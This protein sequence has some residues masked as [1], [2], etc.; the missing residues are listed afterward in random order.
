MEPD[1]RG[2][3]R[4]L[5]EEFHRRH[6][7]I[8]IRL[9]EGPASTDAREDLYVNALL[10]GTGD[11]DLVYADTIWIPKFASAGWL[12][13]LT[14]RWPRERWDDFVPA[15][16]QGGTH[17]SRIYR[18]PVQLNGGLLYYRRDLIGDDPPA[19]FEE[20]VQMAKQHATADGRWGF[21]WQGKQYEGLVCN[22]LEILGGFGGFWID[23]ETREIGLERPEAVAALEFLRDTVGTISPPGVTT[24][25][26]EE[27]RLLFE[28]DGAV[29]LRNWPYVLRLGGRDA[30]FYDRVGIAPMPSQPGV[31]PVSTFGGAGFAIVKST[32]HP[33]AAWAFIEFVTS[34]WAVEFLNERI[35]L[36]PAVRSFYKNSDDPVQR[37]LL[38][39]L[40]T[41]RPRPPLPQY[42][43]ATD[44]LQRYVSA[45]LTRQLEPREALRRA[46]QE[47]RRL[48]E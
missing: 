12:A 6:P 42:A 30:A 3:W 48:L 34:P 40:E 41:T 10:S 29:F 5:F 44:I 27:S 22:F 47:T 35:G 1:G 11:F 43:Q 33:D 24:Y 4:A 15:A 21:V 37:K 45:A 26:E 28:N 46:S 25:A 8:R 16:I 31:D 23:P 39:V 19:T 2:A 14:D 20:F 38:E 9:I 36:Q 7:E 32:P 13:D 17:K 18:V